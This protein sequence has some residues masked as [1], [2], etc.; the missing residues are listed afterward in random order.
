MSPPQ[1]DAAFVA[2]VEDVPDT[3]A[4]PYDSKRP[5]VRVDE[6]GKRL[7]GGVREPL[8][9]RPGSPAKRDHEYERGG[10]ANSFMAFE[11]LAGTRR[12]EVTERGRAR[13]SHGSCGR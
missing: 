6:A 3:Y 8:P 13:T 11:P 9:V 2:N 4:K 7:I 1:A 10:M 12:V 5:V